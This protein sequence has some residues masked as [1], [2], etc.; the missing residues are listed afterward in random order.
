M[1]LRTILVPLLTLCFLPSVY[2][3]NPAPS[4]SECAQVAT[5][6]S[7]FASA[8]QFERWRSG[9]RLMDIA[10][11]QVDVHT[12]LR[13]CG[14]LGYAAVQDLVWLYPGQLRALYR[15][16]VTH[17][18]DY[19]LGL[20]Y[21]T[22]QRGSQRPMLALQWRSG[23]RVNV[24][25]HR[26]EGTEAASDPFGQFVYGAADTLS[27]GQASGILTFLFG[28]PE[29]E[30]EVYSYRF[31]LHSAANIRRLA[32]EPISLLVRDSHG[33]FNRRSF[34]FASFQ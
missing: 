8:D 11:G 29:W 20:S 33:R 16:A 7:G 32:G 6:T 27:K 13:R 34:S 25:E 31:D 28:S 10:S 22:P 5:Y 23:A 4:Y 14:E 30:N 1:N 9:Y 19:H 12:R 17:V 21:A 26:Y 18:P 2:A 3:W 15:Q 24:T